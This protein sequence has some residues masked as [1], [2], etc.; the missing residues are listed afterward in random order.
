VCVCVWGVG[1]GGSWSNQAI[2]GSIRQGRKAST[3]RVYLG[4]VAPSG[5]R[6]IL[7]SCFLVSATV[8]THSGRQYIS[9]VVVC[10]LVAAENAKSSARSRTSATRRGKRAAPFELTCERSE[11]DLTGTFAWYR[12]SAGTG[13][14]EMPIARTI[15]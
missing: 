15:R 7:L 11:L 10:W 12:P 4:C 5:G 1:P 2:S 13:T 8:A 3:F 6:W 9:L 14:P